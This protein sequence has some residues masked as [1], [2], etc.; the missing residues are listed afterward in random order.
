MLDTDHQRA[1]PWLWPQAA[2]AA[3]WAAME[4]MTGFGGHRVELADGALEV[5]VASVNHRSFQITVRG[6]CRDAGVEDRIRRQVRAYAERGAITVSITWES[7]QATAIDLQALREIWRSL[8]DIASELKAPAPHLE[9]LL[10]LVG[11]QPGPDAAAL[12]AAIDQALPVALEA[13]RHHRR[14]EGAALVA[15]LLARVASLRQLLAQ[16]AERA[17][18]RLEPWREALRTR[19]TEAIGNAIPEELIAR[20]CA[21]QADRGDIT[22]EITRFA[23][24]CDAA[25]ILLTTPST[26]I[27]KPLEFLLQEFGREINTMGS[28]SGDAVLTNLVIIGKTLLEQMR[29]QV[30]NLQ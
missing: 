6:D 28:K 30:A 27:G 20:E 10:H 24:H 21:I 19:I 15:D 8:A 14:T 29:E 22:E 3:A 1:R 23:A 26:A 12:S 13:W 11:R 9:S 16:I 7:A 4:S 18:L 17:P 2:T 5:Q 25:E